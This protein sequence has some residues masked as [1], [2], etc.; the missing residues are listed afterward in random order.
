MSRLTTAKGAA[1]FPA[2]SFYPLRFVHSL[3]SICLSKESFKLFTHTPVQSMHRDEETGKWTLQTSKGPLSASKVLLATNG[4]SRALLPSLDDFLLSHRAHCSSIIPPTNYQGEHQLQSTCSI[5]R[6]EDD[7]EYLVQRPSSSSD[8]AFILGGGNTQMDRHQEIDTYDDA[9]VNPALGKYF[10]AYPE[11]SF[12]GW[13]P[14]AGKLSHVWTGI[15]G[16]TRDSLPIVGESFEQRGLYLC[17]GHHGHGMAR[18]A[19]CAR[20]VA[21]LLSLEKQKLLDDYQWSCVTNLPKC[22]RWTKKR[23]ARKDVDHRLDF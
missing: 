19:T 1:V 6:Q 7:Y 16:Y 2:G 5:V 13:E 4:Y 3:L 21:N 10:A 11:K 8:N 15:Q 22:Y 18:A 14:G 12:E 9:Y 23:A 17:L 20:G